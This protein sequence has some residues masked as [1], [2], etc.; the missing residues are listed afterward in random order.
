MNLSE[1]VSYLSSLSRFGMVLGLERI[2]ALCERFGHPEAS[3]RALHIAGTKGKGSVTMMLSHALHAA[4]K[5]VGTFIKPHLYDVRERVMVDL[6][7]IAG[8]EFAALMSEI[9]PAVE[10]VS[11]RGFGTPT[12]FEVKTLL[13]FLHFARVPVDYAVVEVGLGGTYDS[14]NVLDPRISVITNI[15]LD[16]VERLGRTIP[17]IAEQ[18]AGIIK[19][20]RPVVTA[21]R[22]PEALAV[23]ERVAAERDAPLWRIGREF[24]AQRHGYGEGWQRFS[25]RTPRREHADLTLPLAGAFQVENAATA[26]AALDLLG[27]VEEEIPAEA[28]RRGLAEV[29]I[30]GRLEVL[31]RDP[32]FLIDGAHNAASSTALAA[33]LRELYPER[34]RI[35]IL[36]VS[37]D[38]SAAD[39]VGTLAPDSA[40]VIATQA[41][42]PRALPAEAVAAEA[43]RHVADVRIAVP[44]A[45]AV[46]LALEL[47]GPKD[48]I[49]ATG[50]FFVIGEIDRQMVAC[51]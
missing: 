24:E 47:A 42:N 23:I 40:V 49:C 1:A 3:L 25:V 45:D 50:S 48:L 18:K 20:G 44:V 7:P 26:V 36:G 14:T 33:A 13:M 12:E 2:E 29:R 27:T 22:D 15:S 9:K 38:H 43:R 51:A 41:D 35:L 6:Q 46:R 4:G 11:A 37:A 10:E 17:E 8:E 31:R 34:R 30:A 19:P 32:L 5:R 16:H 28:I 39:V 21:A